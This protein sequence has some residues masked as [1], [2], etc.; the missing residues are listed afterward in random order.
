MIKK[1]NNIIYRNYYIKMWRTNLETSKD[2]VYDDPEINKNN[3]PNEKSQLRN[4]Y[5]KLMWLYYPLVPNFNLPEVPLVLNYKLDSTKVLYAKEKVDLEKFVLTKNIK[6]ISLALIKELPGVKITNENKA[7]I[8]YNLKLFIMFFLSMESDWKNIDNFKNSW[9]EWYFQYKINNYW[10]KKTDYSS[11]ETALRRVSNFYS[12]SFNISEDNPNYKQIPDWV[13][14]AWKKSRKKWVV[15]KL[16]AEQQIILFLCDI[17]ERKNKKGQILKELAKH[18][19]NIL[20]NWNQWSI[21]E[22]YENY[23]HTKVKKWSPTHDRV[24]DKILDV[25]KKYGFP[26]KII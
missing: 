18:L 11:F 4:F 13:K 15:E 25:F 5:N 14:K 1:Y 21:R 6:K 24:N 20:F 7:K 19:K 2:N 26:K 17:F 23:H 9:A 3:V 12:G 16:S 8:L 10:H 22:I